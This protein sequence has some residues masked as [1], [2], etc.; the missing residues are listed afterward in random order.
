MS[1][2]YVNVNSNQ[3]VESD[4]RLPHLDKLARWLRSE[5]DKPEPAKPRTP[6]KPKP[7][8]PAQTEPTLPAE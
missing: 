2:R 7:D 4:E 6:R 3:V 5:G 1:F 8:A